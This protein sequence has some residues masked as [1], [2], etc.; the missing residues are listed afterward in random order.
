MLDSAA[1]AFFSSSVI[2]DP[3]VL[4]LFTQT[5]HFVFILD[6]SAG[7][8]KNGRPGYFI[9]QI[10]LKQ[11]RTMAVCCLAGAGQL[12]SW[13]GIRAGDSHF[14]RCQEKASFLPRG[15]SSRRRCHSDVS[16]KESSA[17]AAPPRRSLG[18]L[19]LPADGSRRLI[20]LYL[21]ARVVIPDPPR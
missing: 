20:M 15:A 2:V 13:M 17:T 1:A 19:E 16:K 12:A 3:T 6:I 5:P 10:T 9:C 4:L 7:G 11:E 18:Y 14:Q 8:E 21:A